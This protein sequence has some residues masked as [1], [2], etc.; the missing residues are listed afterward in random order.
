MS[1][2][3]GTDRRIVVLGAGAIGSVVAAALWEKWGR[4]LLLVARRDHVQAVNDRGLSLEG[5]VN[6][7]FRPQAAEAVDF[8]LAGS[9]VIVTTKATGLETALRQIEPY[10]QEDTV[11]LLLQNGY[12][13]RELAERVLRDSPVSRD[14]I[15]LGIVALGA[16]FIEPGRVGY[17]GGNIRLDPGLARTAYKDLLADTFITHKISANLPKDIWTKLAVN[18][19]VNPLSVVLQAQNWVI[20]D[21]AH[22]DMKTLILE[23]VL[24]VAAAEGIPLFLDVNF[25]NRFISSDNY[26][27]MYQDIKRGRKTEIDYLN[28]A[29]VRLADYY[30]IPVPVN[31]FVVNLIKAL[32][33]PH[34]TP[35]G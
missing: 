1:D 23:E 21:P 13:I 14:H 29:I 33:S 10:L 6:A 15:V 8:S 20:A 11:L 9:L 31:R 32:E 3:K 34:P 19:V 35:I 2:F 30:N 24:A 18:A 27:S 4:G 17:Y 28:G 12:G 7:V 25:I 22:D 16:T 26:S 5:K